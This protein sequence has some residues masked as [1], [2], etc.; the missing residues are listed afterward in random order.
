MRFWIEVF[1]LEFLGSM[2]WILGCS[3]LDLWVGLLLGLKFC[4]FFGLDLGLGFGLD[5]LAWIPWVGFWI[6]LF[7]WICLV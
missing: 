4:G 5:S 6:G 2:G 7:F 1:G 3:F